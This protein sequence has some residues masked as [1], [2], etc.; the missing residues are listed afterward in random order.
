[1]TAGRAA[2]APARNRA[3]AK[4]HTA[5]AEDGAGV[6][7][8]AERGWQSRSPRMCLPA[9]EELCRSGAKAG[10]ETEPEVNP[11]GAERSEGQRL[12]CSARGE[13]RYPACLPKRRREQAMREPGWPEAN[14]LPAVLPETKR[15]GARPGTASKASNGRVPAEQVRRRQDQVG[16][17]RAGGRSGGAARTGTE[18][19]KRQA[20]A[21]R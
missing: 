10:A 1:M 12:R 2:V 18:T 8:A 14:S 19:P 6:K 7:A 5:E 13:E 15:S 17:A 4:Q 3:A 11:A 20:E 9:E 21:G 16:K